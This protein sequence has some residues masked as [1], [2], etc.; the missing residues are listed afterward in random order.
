MEPVA[1]LCVA[2]WILASYWYGLDRAFEGTALH[3][4]HTE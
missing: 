4:R 1:W 2:S 3:R